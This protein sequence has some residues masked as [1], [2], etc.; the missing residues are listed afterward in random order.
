MRHLGRADISLLEVRDYLAGIRKSF[1][2][3]LKD[4]E[5][6][7]SKAVRL[8]QPMSLSAAL[9]DILIHLDHGASAVLHGQ[10]GRAR[11]LRDA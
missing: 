10:A 7:A 6:A 8:L 5:A 4:Q 1:E 11:V 3:Y 9:T 2:K